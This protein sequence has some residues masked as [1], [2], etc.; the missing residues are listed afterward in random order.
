MESAGRTFFNSPRVHWMRNALTEHESFAIDG[1]DL[2]AALPIR[3]I[4]EEKV[5]GMIV[6]APGAP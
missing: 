3:V 6:S 1:P 2:G 4:V 5:A